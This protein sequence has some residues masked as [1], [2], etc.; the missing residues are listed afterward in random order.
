MPAELSWRG[1]IERRICSRASGPLG[2]GRSGLGRVANKRR[3]FVSHYRKMQPYGFDFTTC[4]GLLTQVQGIELSNEAH[5]NKLLRR[6]VYT[7]GDILCLEKINLNQ[8]V[9]LTLD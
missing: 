4:A 8:S 9:Y 2:Q 6:R 1:E 3:L 7:L 5:S